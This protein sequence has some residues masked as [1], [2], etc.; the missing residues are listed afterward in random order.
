MIYEKDFDVH[1]KF[2]DLEE[3]FFEFF[4]EE[5]FHQNILNE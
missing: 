2:F 5:V 1:N 3:K 4:E